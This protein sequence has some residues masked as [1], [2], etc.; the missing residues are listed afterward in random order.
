MKQKLHI[1]SYQIIPLGFLGLILL[2]TALLLLPISTAPGEHTGPLTALFTATTSVCVTGLVVV[3]TFSHW[4]FFGQ[5]VILFLIQMG[6]LGVITVSS[7]VILLLYRRMTLGEH[8]LLMSAFNLSSPRGMV[9]FLL[10]VLRGTFYVEGIG[11][12][13]YLIPFLPE[14]GLRGVWIALFT[15]VS[16]F[17]NAGIDVLGSSSLIVYQNDPTVLLPTMALIILGGLGY[18]VW[19]DLSG[20]IL[21]GKKRLSEHAKLVFSLT[22]ALIVAGWLLT[23]LFEW[24]NPNTLGSLPLPSKMLNALFQSVTYR[25]AGFATVPQSAL[26]ESSVLVGSVLMF[27]GGSPVGTAGG[28][29]TVTLYAVVKHAVAYIFDRD[30]TVIFHRRLS[31]DMVRQATAIVTVSLGAVLAFVLALMLATGFSL[32]DC[33]FEVVS[34]LATVGLSRDLTPLLNP[35]GR[36]LIILAMYLGR[37]GPISLALFFRARRRRE[38]AVHVAEGTFIIG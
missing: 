28:V 8:V 15:A 3:D 19:F 36:L 37:I 33:L 26:R 27:I 20:L 32:T 14:F 23:L 21:D 24:D 2:G 6:G 11:A 31:R 7:A 1:T 38:N 25:T 17:C 22:A 13:L 4:S 18:V 5:L 30:E 9:R 12:L 29:K 10:Q 35:A 16:A 34:A